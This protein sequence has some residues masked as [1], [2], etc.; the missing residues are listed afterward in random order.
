MSKST[1]VKHNHAAVAGSPYSRPNPTNIFEFNTKVG[2]HI[3]KNPGGQF[4]IWLSGC[5][6]TDSS[7]V[8]A[9]AIVQ[10]ANLR[11]S[12]TVLEVGPGTGNLTVKILEKAKKVTAV[13]LDPRMAAEVTK[14]FQGTPEQ[15]RLEVLLGDVIKT[16]LP[17]FDVCISNTPYQVY[18]S[19]YPLFEWYTDQEQIS[20]PLIFKLLALPTPPRTCILMLQREFAL[21]LVARPSD[22]LYC[23]LSVNVQLFARVTHI[24]KVGKNNFRPPPQVESSVVRIEPKTG[25][26]RPGVSWREWDG[27]LRICFIRK[28][29][30]LRASWL[31]SKKVLAMCEKNFKVW[32]A[33]NDAVKDMEDA[34]GPIDIPESLEG[35][36]DEEQWENHGNMDMDTDMDMDEDD[37]TKTKS[38]SKPT[39][40]AQLVREK[41][42]KVLEVSTELADK[43]AGQCDQSDFLRLLYA[44]NKE[45]I[46]FA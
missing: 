5:L 6:D 31:G 22:S 36:P 41:I 7:H 43:R 30:T 37:P 18:I 4:S 29:K 14:R 23:R 27:M 13:E 1:K 35:F 42:R 45:G 11:P 9:A 8:V 15:K 16:E 33:L 19:K 38:I 34:R 24:M 21:R 25:A 44:F 32:C 10:K 39:K 20:S 12:D 2:Q 26:E 28:N 3:L 40:V 46:H 17:N